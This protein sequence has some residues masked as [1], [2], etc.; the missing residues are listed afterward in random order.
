VS[1]AIWLIVAVAFIARILITAAA[2]RNWWLASGIIAGALGVYAA[3]L[4]G[5][6]EVVAVLRWMQVMLG[7]YGAIIIAVGIFAAG[8]AI[9]SLLA[10]SDRSVRWRK[11]LALFV[12]VVMTALAVD[13][14]LSVA[15]YHRFLRLDLWFIAGAAAYVALR[16]SLFEREDGP[17]PALDDW[18]AA[19]R[20]H[21]Q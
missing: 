17:S 2:L 5:G 9:P 13:T 10:V 18:R 12:S 3:P 7:V 11:A 1:T 15:P 14:W 8:Y 20:R 21:R 16:S 4:A 6:V 19:D